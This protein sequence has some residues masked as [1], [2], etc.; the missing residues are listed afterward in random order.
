ME[1]TLRGWDFLGVYVISEIPVGE[2]IFLHQLKD[3]PSLILCGKNSAGAYEIITYA[4]GSFPESSLKEIDVTFDSKQLQSFG[5]SSDRNYVHFTYSGQTKV[6]GN[7]AADFM[8]LFAG[9]TAYEKNI[10]DTD[11]W[12][13]NVWPKLE[14]QQLYSDAWRMLRE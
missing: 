7:N 4:Y 1:I 8:N 12:V 9:D 14:Y 10:I 2:Y 11:R 5:V 3:D 13:L 6:F